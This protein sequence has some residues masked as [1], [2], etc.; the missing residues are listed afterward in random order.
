MWP[1]LDIITH[2]LVWER[3]LP[4]NNTVFCD[5]AL[6]LKKAYSYGMKCLWNSLQKSLHPSI[7]PGWYN[8]WQ[9]CSLFNI[10]C[11]Y[12]F[13][14]FPN[15]CK[16]RFVTSGSISTTHD[17]A[18]ICKYLYLEVH[19]LVNFGSLYIDM[20]SG[21]LPVH[22]CLKFSAGYIIYSTNCITSYCIAILWI[23]YWC[24][25]LV[26]HAKEPL[27]SSSSCR[28]L[29]V[30][31]IC[32]LIVPGACSFILPWVNLKNNSICIFVLTLLVPGGW[33][34]GC[35][36]SHM[37]V[38]VP[39]DHHFKCIMFPCHPWDFSSSHIIEECDFYLVH[40]SVFIS[41]GYGLLTQSTPAAWH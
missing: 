10:L 14:G 27:H 39:F 40:L 21:F 22:T 11:D 15:H 32:A 1:L 23:Q 12:I 20:V 8:N 4:S 2:P 35:W 13:I 30:W 31:A 3:T 25:S 9:V 26:S 28:A 29:S 17:C 38:R 34:V 24:F 7:L 36:Y 37:F 5:N 19:V 16:F 41:A 33:P 18:A 6:S